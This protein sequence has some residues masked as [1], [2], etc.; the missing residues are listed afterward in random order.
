MHKNLLEPNSDDTI[1]TFLERWLSHFIADEIFSREP[2]V[3]WGAASRTNM[4]M[5]IAFLGLILTLVTVEGYM[6]AVPPTS[7]MSPLMGSE[8]V[9]KATV[10]MKKKKLKE[11][12]AI[13]TSMAENKDNIVDVSSTKRCIIFSPDS[14]F[15]PLSNSRTLFSLSHP[16]IDMDSKEGEAILGGYSYRVPQGNCAWERGHGERNG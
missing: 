14:T 2:R 11:V 9:S 8:G 4:T 15:R 7:R 10:M 16:H 3:F 5:I 1:S 6:R 13:K 12:T